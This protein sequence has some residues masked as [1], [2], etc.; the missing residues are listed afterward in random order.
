MSGFIL[1]NNKGFKALSSLYKGI[2]RARK[3][4]TERSLPDGLESFG[5]FDT[6]GLRGPVNFFP[7]NHQGLYHSKLYKANPEKGIPMPITD[8]RRAPGRN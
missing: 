5:N 7:T 8:W 4:L 1:L 2:R 3:N 6:K